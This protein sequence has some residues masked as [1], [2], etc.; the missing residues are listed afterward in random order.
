MRTY[1]DIIFYYNRSRLRALIGIAPHLV[2][3]RMRIRIGYQDTRPYL[4]VVA[5]R[6][7]ITAPYSRAT[8]SDT[9]SYRQ[10]CPL[11]Q[12]NRPTEITRNRIHPFTR[13][14]IEIISNLDFTPPIVK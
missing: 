4:H 12:V 2:I 7:T 9:P 8:H 6:N 10:A 14:V 11:F 13:R 5:Y 3:H 1:P